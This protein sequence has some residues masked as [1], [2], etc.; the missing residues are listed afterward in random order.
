MSGKKTRCHKIAQ[1]KLNDTQKKQKNDR[2]LGR[3][4]VVSCVGKT[5][6]LREMVA[7][8]TNLPPRTRDDGSYIFPD[9]RETRLPVSA[10]LFAETH[11]IGQP[12]P[13]KAIVKRLLSSKHEGKM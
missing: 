6:F 10:F 1:S 2:L 11:R 7:A 5:R 13:Y 3:G 8:L 9:G 4:V 12:A